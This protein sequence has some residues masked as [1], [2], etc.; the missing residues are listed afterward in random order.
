MPPLL[1]S[2]IK[3]DNSG[4]APNF[5]WVGLV[6]LF[7][8]AWVFFGKGKDRPL[9]GRFHGNAAAAL[10]AVGI[11]LWV[12]FP[13][14]PLYPSWPVAYSTGGSLGFYLMPMGRGVVAKN[15]GEMYL[16]FEKTYRFVFAAREKLEG[17]RLAYG[18]MKGEHEIGLRYFDAPLRSPGLRADDDGPEAMARTNREIRE[19]VFIQEACY[20]LKGLY[21]YEIVL[22]LKSFPTRTFSTTLISANLPIATRNRDASFSVPTASAPGTGSSTA[23]PD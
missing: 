1:P 4:Y 5:V 10:L 22:S 15:D 14:V 11:L 12:A 9:S 8:A 19:T 2:F 6:V 21:L 7:I 3:V 13:R 20:R 18:S 16:H 23:L 17:I